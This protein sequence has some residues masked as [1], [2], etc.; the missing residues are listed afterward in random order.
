MFYALLNIQR[1]FG[2]LFQALISLLR[3]FLRFRFRSDLN[4]IKAPG[5]ELVILANGPSLR[6]DLE[7]HPGFFEGKQLLVV[8]QF[9]VSQAYEQLKPKYYMVLD[10]GFFVEN[11]IPRV[12]EAREQVM[13]ALIRKTTWPITLFCPAEGRNSRFHRELKASGTPVT[14]AFINKTVVDGTRGIRHWLYRRQVGMPPP[15]NVLIG[16]LM[17]GLAIGFKRIIILGAD[18]S[19]LQ[20]LKMGEDGKLVSE[21]NHFYDQKPWIA[22]VHH[23]ETLKRVNM[24]DYLFNMYRTFRS[25]FLVQEFAESIGT[26]IINASSV[27]FIDAFERKKL[28]DYPW[29]GD[30]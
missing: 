18:H 24:H 4:R 27:S 19:W 8:N 3:V 15:Q 17:A 16:A 13:K 11:T 21:E 5:K 25:Y 2:S 22:K 29:D 28:D 20:S 14:F 10:I 30:R 26:R 7:T 1:F 9:A 12:A 6:T 23:P